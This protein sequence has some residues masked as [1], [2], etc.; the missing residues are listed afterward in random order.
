M[1]K[2]LKKFLLAAR[3]AQHRRQVFGIEMYQQ[4]ILFKEV[5]FNPED[6][7]SK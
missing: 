3:P 6:P 4:R 2:S 5:N 1:A 7:H